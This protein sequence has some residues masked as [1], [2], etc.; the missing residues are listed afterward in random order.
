[1]GFY[2][3]LDAVQSLEYI[4]DLTGMERS[5]ASEKIHETLEVVGLSEDAH[6]KVGA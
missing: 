1:V 4:A 2:S 3:D 5:A 6:K